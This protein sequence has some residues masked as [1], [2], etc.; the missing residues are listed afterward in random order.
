MSNR[1]HMDTPEAVEVGLGPYAWRDVIAIADGAPVRLAAATVERLARYRSGVD[2]IVARGTRAY[3]ITTGLGALSDVLLSDDQVAALSTN[4]VRS[5]ACAIGEP[6]A[7]RTV[8][9][10]MAGQVFNFCHGHS[11]ISPGVALQIADLLNAGITP[12]IPS[13]GSV[14]YIAHTSHV[15]LALI[16]EGMVEFGGAVWPAAEALRLCGLEPIRLGAKEGLSLVNGTPCLVGLSCLVIEEALRI[17]DWADLV[18]A[19]SFEVLGG[20]IAAFDPQALAVKRHPAVQTVGRRLRSFL[21]GSE[22]VAANLGRRTQD[23]LSIRS[24]PQIHG[25]I[26]EALGAMEARIE[27][28]LNSATDNPLLFFDGEEPRLVSQ[29]NPHGEPVAIALDSAAIALAEFGGVSERRL[30]RLVNPLVSGLPAFLVKESGVNSGFM[31]V[32]YA[33]ASLASENKILA[34]PSVIDNYVTSGLQEDHLSL[35][36]P[37]ALKALRITDNVRRMLAIEY[38]AA[39]QAY[40]FMDGRRPGKGTAQGLAHL[41][42]VIPATDRDR[43]MSP[44]LAAAAALLRMPC[45]V[46]A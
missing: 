4:T 29:A 28:E 31:I 38:L 33:A 21:E 10:I 17:A 44:D 3:G 12:V 27:G 24:I 41:R 16:G 36:T 30:D 37:A 43:I 42:A 45:P 6:F 35:G 1:P 46:A 34:A 8:R 7:S 15:G 25:G 19:M 13:Q 18:G 2:R 22:I 20:Q 9:A 14:G 39:A 5:H 40:E 23:A 32:Q 11:G 26:R